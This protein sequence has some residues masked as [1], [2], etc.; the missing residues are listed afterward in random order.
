M[1]IDT[2]VHFY[3]P[4]MGS[5]AWPPKD[6]PYYR[7]FLPDDLFAE[8]G[9][10]LSACV[11]VGCSNEFELNRRLLDALRDDARVGAYIAQLDPAD[12]QCA[13][14]AARYAMEPKYRGFRVASRTALPYADRVSSLIAP[15]GI[16]ELQGNWRDTAAWAD[17]IASHPGTTFIVE[18]FGGFLFDG[19]PVPAE[20]RDFCRRFAAFP[21]TAVKLSGFFTLCRIFPKP[22]EAGVYREA[23]GAMYDAFG[24]DRCMFGSDWP[25]AGMPY[26]DCVS[27]FRSLTGAT[28]DKTMSEA[29]GRLYRIDL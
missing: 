17:F 25:V 24:P 8:A 15:G 14:Y 20:Y 12:P 26:A 16:V 21:N 27:V 13:A 3:D 6:S 1:I 11:A 10:A 19:T 29:A 18:H 5:F 28:C 2:H 22:T 7:R 4:R 9:T 23:F